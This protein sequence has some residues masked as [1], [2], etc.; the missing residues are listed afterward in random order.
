MAT[1]KDTKNK[2][3]AQSDRPKVKISKNGPYLVSGGIS[4]MTLSISNDAEGYPYEYRTGG[5]Y[6]LQ[7]NYALC[8]CGRSDNK[9]YCDRTHTKVKFKGTETASRKSYLDQAEEVDGP[10]LKLTDLRL[11]CSSAG[12]CRRAGGIRNLIIHSDNLEAKNIAIE[13]AG[14]C[15]AGRIVVW[16][17]ETGKAIEPQFERSI[18]LVEEPQKGVSGPIWVRGGIPVES[19]EGTVYETRNRIALCNC[20]ESSNKPF[21]DGSHVHYGVSWRKWKDKFAHTVRVEFKQDPR[22][23]PS[24]RAEE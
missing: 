15:T 10:V 17:K 4:L 20:G 3:D 22:I 7:E 23:S 12:F 24:D 11:L 16:D 9:P 14:H 8:R 21:C 2:N 6:P 1:K 5:T 19:A 13:E 18:A